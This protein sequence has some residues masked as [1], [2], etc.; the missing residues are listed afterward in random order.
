[1]PLY[2]YKCPK[3]HK[4]EEKLLGITDK[5]I[6]LCDCGSESNR[7]IAPISHFSVSGYS[8]DNGYSNGGGH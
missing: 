2:I 8:Y 5:P 6:V 7:V 3:C 4:E 1:M